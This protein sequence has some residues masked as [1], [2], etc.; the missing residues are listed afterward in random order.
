MPQGLADDIHHYRNKDSIAVSLAPIGSQLGYLFE[1]INNKWRKMNQIAWLEKNIAEVEQLLV[2]DQD[3]A[4][5]N[6]DSF[7]ARLSLQS[8]KDRLADLQKQLQLEK[9]ST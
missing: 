2:A 3:V 8:T 6:P 7:S 5:K 1:K 4:Q 9:R